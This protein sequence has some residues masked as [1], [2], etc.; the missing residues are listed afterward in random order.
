MQEKKPRKYMA[1]I[2][3]MAEQRSRSSITAEMLEEG[4]PA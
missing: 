3:I 2:K 1:S 4:W